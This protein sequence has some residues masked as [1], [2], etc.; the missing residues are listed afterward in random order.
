[1]F[2]LF[3][4]LISLSLF[5]RRVSG[6][7]DPL[8]RYTY[9]LPAGITFLL[10]HD[11]FPKNSDYYTV[12]FSLLFTLVVVSFSNPKYCQP[13]SIKKSTIYVLMAVSIT[14]LIFTIFDTLINLD[15]RNSVYMTGSF[16]YRGDLNNSAFRFAA[17]S[18]LELSIPAYVI[19][20]NYG[21]KFFSRI[22]LLWIIIDILLSLINPSKA[23]VL[24]LLSI[25]LDWL[26]W[27]KVLS[28]K[29]VYFKPIINTNMLIVSKRF[30]KQLISLSTVVLIIIISTLIALNY[31][32]NFDFAQSYEILKFRLFDASYD[33]AF[34][35][36]K[37]DDVNL[38]LT[39]FPANEFSNI[40]ELWLKPIFKN[41]FKIEYNYDTIPKYIDF[42]RSGS[43][44]NYGISS[45]NSNLFLETTILHGRILGLFIMSSIVVFGAYIRRK[46][47]SLRVIDTKFICFIPIILKGPVF[48]FQ[49]SLGFFTGYFY[50]YLT[51]VI[52]FGIII[53]FIMRED[54]IVS[55]SK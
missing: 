42:I 38:D 37:S 11:K 48:C 9:L 30:F 27:W 45:P 40:I 47:L 21:Y 15:L 7:E 51:L 50:C 23:L 52:F 8:I 32:L 19:T 24:N 17:S 5:F 26:F 6:L 13:K 46:Y 14:G 36:I 1:M 29:G 2:L 16:D 39:N 35:V 20:R 22:F 54:F 34:N 4:I 33:L 43:R 44:G 28:S 25:S 10:L 41:L 12:F 18:L 49:E 3:I 53:N 55:S 31:L